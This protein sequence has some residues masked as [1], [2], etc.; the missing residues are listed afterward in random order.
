MMDESVLVAVDL[1]YRYYGG[2][3]VLSGVSFTIRR[4]E[5]VGILGANGA[6]KSTLVLLLAGL[7]KPSSGRV[8]LFGVDTTSRSL[9]KVRSRL[10][11]VF[12]DPEDQLFNTTVFEDVVYGPR[13]L[14]MGDAER[15]AEEALRAVKA[16]H[17]KDRP[18]H[19][20][21]FGEKK[22]VAIATALAHKPEALLLDEPTANLDPASRGSLVALLNGLS[23]EGV[24]IVIS[25][26]DIE[27]LPDLVDRVIVLSEGKVIGDSS[28]SD[29]L[30]NL[31]LLESASL[32][33]PTMVRMAHE[34]KE[35][36]LIE[37]APTDYKGMMDA[38]TRALEGRSG[39][40]DLKKEGL[41]QPG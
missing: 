5:R 23:S 13:T 39:K 26:H 38:I 33:P 10:G 9:E 40:N 30:S 8:E 17:L 7:L 31:D 25:T 14:G 2:I 15:S 32:A 22:R 24:T 1:H 28:L 27:A 11:V 3:D 19:R 29:T 6:G 41:R 16:L 21:S 34:L 35:R 12:Q 37:A 4:G 36:G 18:P 20:L